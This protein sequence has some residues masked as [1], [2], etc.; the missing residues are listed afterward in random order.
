M[1]TSKLTFAGILFIS[2]A[3]LANAG[4]VDTT[5]LLNQY[6][7]ITAGDVKSTSEVEGNALIGGNVDGGMY[8]MHQ[9]SNAVVP[10]LTVGSNVNGNV[11]TNG[12][13]LNVGGNVAGNVTMNDGGDAVVGSVSGSLQNNANGNGSSSVT[14]NISGNVNTNGGNTTYGG[15]LARPDSAKA[16]G[17]GKVSNQPVTAPFAPSTVASNAMNVLS[18]FSTQLSTL[19]ANSGYTITSGKVTFNAVGNDS[20]LAI[21][22]ISDAKTFFDNAFEF[23]FSMTNTQSILFNVFSGGNTELDIKANFLA[24]AATVWGSLFLWNFVDA[25]ELNLASQF[26]GSILALNAGVTNRNNIEGTLVAKSLKQYGEIHSQPSNFVPPTEVPVPAALPL[27]LSGLIG[28]FSL[29]RNRKKT[30]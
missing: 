2:S 5:S 17:G 1:H 14:G 13:G 10:S 15:S 6:N 29:R 27:F 21:F 12:Q 8:N 19:D 16:N 7:L 4:P 18:Q 26:G 24:S 9:T 11:I 3:Q 30:N 28:F 25:T 23:D 22:S 20:G